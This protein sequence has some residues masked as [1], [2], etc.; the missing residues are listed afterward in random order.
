M[1]LTV[2]V[3]EPLRAVFGR[4]QLAVRADVRNLGNARRRRFVA[5]TIARHD[6]DRSEAPGEGQLLLVRQHLTRQ[7]HQAE[8]G[9]SVIDLSDERIIGVVPGQVYAA[10]FDTDGRSE[11]SSSQA[12]HVRR[13]SRLTSACS[14]RHRRPASGR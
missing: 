2:T 14:C 1:P 13:P 8:F 7:Q 12:I 6:V 10:Q 5:V 4:Q 11:R 3:R 9:G